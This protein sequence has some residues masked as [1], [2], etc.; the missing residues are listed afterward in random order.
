MNG[1]NALKG[2]I[3]WTPRRRTMPFTCKIPI[4]PMR[5]NLLV[6]MK[7]NF[8]FFVLYVL[9]VPDAPTPRA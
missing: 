5:K 8:Y 7:K 4:L 9:H 2:H 3:F 1:I 6:Q